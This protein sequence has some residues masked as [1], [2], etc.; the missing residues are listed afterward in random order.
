MEEEVKIDSNQILKHPP[1]MSKDFRFYSANKKKCFHFQQQVNRIP[2][3]DDLSNTV[4]SQVFEEVSRDRGHIRSN[5]SGF[6]T[7]LQKMIYGQV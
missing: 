4:T 6:L 3:E 7:M 5:L 2:E 1:P